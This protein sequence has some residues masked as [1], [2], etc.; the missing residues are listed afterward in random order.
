[1]VTAI[2]AARQQKQ[3]RQQQLR[4][5]EIQQSTKKGTTERATA[6]ETTT[7]TDSNDN[8]VGA[9]ANDSA[10]TTATRTTCPGCALQWWRWRRCQWWGGGHDGNGKLQIVGHRLAVQRL[11][12]MDL[13]GQLNV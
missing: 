6:T 9:N 7:V 12:C 4:W 2:A 10:S 11:G 3:P 5:K 13:S 1:M 8:D